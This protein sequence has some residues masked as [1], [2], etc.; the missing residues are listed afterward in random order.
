MITP[1]DEVTLR[2]L[3]KD[4]LKDIQHICIQEGP[5]GKI[6]ADNAR[7]IKDYY[8]N[9]QEGTQKTMLRIATNVDTLVGTTAG[10]TK[11][12]ADLLSYQVSHEGEDRG[13]KKAADDKII[14]VNLTAQTR[15]DRITRRYQTIGAIIAFIGLATGIFFGFQKIN[16]ELKKEIQ[17]EFS[18]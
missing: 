8:G 1:K 2:G 12:I 17:T 6:A 7:I 13:K 11:I 3:I 10:H 18:K 5:L 15:R 4:E 16:K 9:G 14:A